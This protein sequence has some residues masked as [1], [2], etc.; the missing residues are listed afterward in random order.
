MNFWI[1]LGHQLIRKIDDTEGTDYTNG[2]GRP[3][4]L[5]PIG[6]QL[7]TSDFVCMSKMSF[8]FGTSARPEVRGT[9]NVGWRSIFPLPLNPPRTHS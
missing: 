4:S 5:N 3:L 7:I 2:S 6:H 9:A 8:F 1:N